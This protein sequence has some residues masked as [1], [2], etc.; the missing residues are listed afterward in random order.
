MEKSI[1][2]KHHSK[3]KLV[4]LCKYFTIDIKVKDF[5]TDRK[6]QCTQLKKNSINLEDITISTLCAP[7]NIF[8][9][10]YKVK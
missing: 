8:T 4:Q 9:K 6:A 2:H 10:I 3:R 7:N 5:V 1:H